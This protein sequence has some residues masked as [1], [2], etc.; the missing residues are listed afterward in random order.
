MT[1]NRRRLAWWLLP[2][3]VGGALWAGGPA[4]S[5]PGN[6][7]A[8][9]PIPDFVADA[10]ADET[11]SIVVR[12]AFN[13]RPNATVTDVEVVDE[14][15]PSHLG[16]PPLSKVDVLG[17]TGDLIQT[18]HD[19]HP[20]WEL[21][22]DVA[23]GETRR[24]N[25]QA[26]GRWIAPFD[27]DATTIVVTDIAAEDEIVRADLTDAIHEFCLAH[28]DDEDCLRADLAVE[29]VGVTT[30]PPIGLVGQEAT[31]AVTTVVTNNGPDGPADAGLT[32]TAVAGPGLTVTPASQT[33]TLT[34]V[35]VGA[36]VTDTDQWTVR[37][38]APGLRT[39]TFT[40]TVAT[41]HAADVDLVPGNNTRST[42]HTVDCA[43]PVTV[44]IKPGGDPNSINLGAGGDT[45]P[46]AVLTTA[47]GEYGN[48]LA[49][50]ATTI[51]ATT[52]RFGDRAV[53]LGGGGGAETHGRRHD[54]RS[55][56]LDERTRDADLDAVLHFRASEGGFTPDDT[57]GCLVGTFTTAAGSFSFFGCGPVRIVP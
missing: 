16:A 18:F 46:L 44:N 37:C 29:A 40:S 47:A 35:A 26:K 21:G 3:A 6:D 11:K 31:I 23:G 17:E 41:V 55:Y 5:E 57:E 28:P 45:V 24:L 13:G 15:A 22:E 56:E 53:V 9:E 34:G 54:E 38:D 43:V 4:L 30:A 33:A 20:M 8:L 7:P 19:W 25:P 51:V 27:R 52:A 39:V 50:D 42:T 14:R 10:A 36:D 49:F 2:L 32:T 12:V 1:P 48:P